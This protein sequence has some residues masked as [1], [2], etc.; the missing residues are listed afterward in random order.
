MRALGDGATAPAGGTSSPGEATIAQF[1]GGRAMR[2]LW[3][4]RKVDPAVADR[5]P[6]GQTS[7]KKWPVLTYG[8]APRI[9]MAT[10]TFRCFG[11]VEQETSW[12]WPDLLAL[13][14]KAVDCDIHCVTRWSLL[15]N[16]F[17]GVAV[18]E[19]LR[20]ITLKPEARYVLVHADPDDYTT[21]L[22]LEDL[23]TDDAL[24]AL[25]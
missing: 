7:T 2:D 11:L 13:P 8:A 3:P 1:A 4:F 18:Q 17:V 16:H 20:R 23:D 19:I 22:A 21:N 10:W 9:D 24:L 14:K 15:D 5:I 6:P 25:E 12:S